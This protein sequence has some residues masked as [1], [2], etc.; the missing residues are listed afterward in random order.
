MTVRMLVMSKVRYIDRK[1]TS[2]DEHDSGKGDYRGCDDAF[3]CCH[4]VHDEYPD[5]T[6]PFWLCA[7]SEPV[8]GAIKR[9]GAARYQLPDWL[10]DG[11][12]GEDGHPDA[13][14]DDRITF[15]W[16]VEVPCGE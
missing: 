13:G 11:V 5:L 15:W 16:W 12:L 9:V 14:E 10:W 2:K 1:A 4:E 8:E 3:V 6:T 7:S